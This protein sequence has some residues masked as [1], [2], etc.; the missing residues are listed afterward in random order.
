MPKVVSE[1]ERKDFQLSARVTDDLK[2]RVA[3]IAEIED[4]TESWV[5]EQLI[6]RGLQMYEQG[7]SLK[8]AEQTNRRKKVA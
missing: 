7:G 3:Q 8:A 6:L 2:K 5:V 1:K 4:R